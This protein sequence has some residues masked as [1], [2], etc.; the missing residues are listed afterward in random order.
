MVRKLL[1]VCYDE[2]LPPST[3]EFLERAECEM[4]CSRALG[5][6]LQRFYTIDFD[7]ILINQNVSSAQEHL[8]V[9]LVREKSKIPIVFVSESVASMPSG[10]DVWLKPPANPEELMRVICALVPDR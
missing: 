3:L 6:A 8:L 2:C 10:V 5:V 9:E 7:L 1:S 4:T